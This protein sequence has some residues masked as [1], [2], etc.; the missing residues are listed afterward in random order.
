MYEHVNLAFNIENKNN[1]LYLQLKANSPSTES[2]T[3]P[4]PKK[5]RKYT[6]KGKN[7]AVRMVKEYGSTTVAAEEI[8][9]PLAT[10]SI[11]M[12]KRKE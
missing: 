1:Y 6:L 7:K 3:P 2:A 12:G 4:P 10:L 5:K 11:W 8:G 9:I